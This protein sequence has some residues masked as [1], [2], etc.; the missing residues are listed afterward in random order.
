MGGPVVA[1]VALV[2]LVLAVPAGLVARGVPLGP[3]ASYTLPAGHARLTDDPTNAASASCTRPLGSANPIRV[4]QAESP[5]S[6]DPAASL[7][8]PGWG[9]IQQ[10]YQGLV[11]YNGTSSTSF[12]GV[13]AADNF[14]SLRDGPTGLTSW[15]F[16]LR[17]A[18]HFSNGD[19]YNAYVQW[20][21]LYRT[22]LMAQAPAFILEQN[23]YATNFSTT[24]PLT[25][26]SSL[27]ASQ[28]ANSTLLNDLNTWNFD[29]PTAREVSQMEVPDQSFQVIDALTIQLN[30]GYGYLATSYDYLL[31]SLSSPESYA[32]DPNFVQ[33]EGGVQVAMPSAYL[34]QYTLGTGAYTVPGPVLATAASITF[35][36]DPGYWGTSAAAEE[37]W[38]NLLQP[39]NT[40][41]QVRFMPLP[42]VTASELE[43]GTVASGSF[44]ELEPQMISTLQSD[45]C[46]VVEPLPPAYSADNGD[47]WIFLDQHRFPFNNLSVREAVAH[48]INYPQI[49]QQAFGGFAQ[50]WV[51][52]VPP[53]YPEYN[54]A[55]LSAYGYDLSLAQREIQNSPCANSAC[56]GLTFKYDYLNTPE[57]SD[58]S[59]LV[60]ADLAAIGLTISPVPLSL[61][62]I[63]AMQATDPVGICVSA[64]PIYGGPFYIG[65]DVYVSDYLAPDDWTRNDAL[66]NGSANHC[67]SEYS[68]STVDRFVLGAASSPSAATV[69]SDYSGM[70][71]LM[72]HNVSDVWFLAPTEFAVY[73]VWLRGVVHNPMASGEPAATLFNTQ[74]VQKP[75]PAPAVYALTFSET[76]LPAATAWS[77]ELNRVYLNGTT[78][79][80]AFSEPNG[81][82]AFLI[83][84]VSGYRSN[85]T[86][87][88]LSI[89]GAPRALE[90]GFSQSNS[91]GSV[92][93]GFS[94]ID[95]ALIGG[96]IAAGIASIVIVSN[97][98]RRRGS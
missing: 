79:K 26:Y 88:N 69:T 57:W 63:Y 36:P 32:V 58:A 1:A 13:L 7:T 76:G 86:S 95:W 85:I 30:P 46:L 92:Y 65:Q 31:A 40:S 21:S 35:T 62:E 61:A 81:T 20:F 19:P 42:S 11:N 28:A 71:G 18:V 72:Y 50:P 74:W 39:A 9:A 3:A 55:G 51:G 75:P 47:W 90:V 14:S 93:G 37:P 70:T 34:S 24:T 77:V 2:V 4:D 67:M 64:T 98:A 54:P 56:A 5:D 17:P 73:S 10:V 96:T 94:L 16:H 49:I 84:T 97:R 82:Y 53:G 52:P 27:A 44:A 48:A 23:F 89:S 15:V 22:L 60:Q 29:H 83:G 43:A 38:N 80:V 59:T 78:S 41:I 91:G 12:A 66:T 87:G 45:P 68:N 6:L 25:Y 33:Q 8:T